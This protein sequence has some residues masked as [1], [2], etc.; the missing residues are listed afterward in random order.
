MVYNYL[1]YVMKNHF[2]PPSCL[3]ATNIPQY[4]FILLNG[5]NI[6]TKQLYRNASGNI[7]QRCVW[8]WVW[9]LKT[10]TSPVSQIPHQQHHCCWLV[11]SFPFS[12][13]LWPQIQFE[14]AFYGFHPVSL[15]LFAHILQS[16]PRWPQDKWISNLPISCAVGAFSAGGV[17]GDVYTVFKSVFYLPRWDCLRSYSLLFVLFRSALAYFLLICSFFSSFP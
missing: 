2:I 16:H 3:Q 14:G 8:F 9:K 12:R 7:L 15:F 4:P 6:V 13:A 17:C 10:C 11:L 5:Y 1:L